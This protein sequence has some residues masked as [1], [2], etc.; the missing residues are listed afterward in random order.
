MHDARTASH[1]DRRQEDSIRQVARS[2]LSQTA[3]KVEDEEEVT[4]SLILR[5]RPHSS[6]GDINDPRRHPQ[7]TSHS[8]PAKA[9]SKHYIGE[10]S[11][12]VSNNES[13]DV[14]DESEDE[15][16]G[17]GPTPTAQVRAPE[18]YYQVFG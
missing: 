3:T 9:V 12:Q 6:L 13:G 16:N 10:E 2:S 4:N 17:I 14:D 18:F 5:R 11:D 1:H 7:S 15:L 8:R